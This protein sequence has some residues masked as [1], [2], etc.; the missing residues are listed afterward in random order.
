MDGKRSF[1]SVV[2]DMHK[3]KGL[4]DGDSECDEVYQRSDWDEADRVKREADTETGRCTRN[5]TVRD[6]SE[7]HV[8]GRARMTSDN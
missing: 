3:R 5:R 2:C 4:M 1:D 8:D 7:E 6:G